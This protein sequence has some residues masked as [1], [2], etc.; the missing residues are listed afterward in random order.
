MINAEN[1][2]N[3][4][5]IVLNFYSDYPR[6]RDLANLSTFNDNVY[7]DVTL[8]YQAANNKTVASMEGVRI[9]RLALDPAD[10]PYVLPEPSYELIGKINVNLTNVIWLSNPAKEK[11]Q[12]VQEE[13]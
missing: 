6:F 7:I 11:A 3:A 9:D 2:P 10:G 13:N 1:F 4:E 8:G 5:C 12:T